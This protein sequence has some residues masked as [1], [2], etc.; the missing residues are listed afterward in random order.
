MTDTPRDL[1][2]HVPLEYRRDILDLWFFFKCLQGHYDLDAY[3]Y[4]SFKTFTYS[5]LNSE[6]VLSKERF[7]TLKC[8]QEL[9]F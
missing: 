5:M 6:G 1:L 2:G 9:I 4:V 7:R 8:I 3:S